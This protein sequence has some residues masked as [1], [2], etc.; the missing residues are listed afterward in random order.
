MAAILS[1][2]EPM[3]VVVLPPVP[4]VAS[5]CPAG[6][7]LAF[8]ALDGAEKSRPFDAAPAQRGIDRAKRT[9]LRSS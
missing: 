4:K 6:A 1:V 8:Q 9:S 2:E 3:S 5:S 7:R